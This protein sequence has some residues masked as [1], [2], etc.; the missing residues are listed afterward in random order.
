MD[1]FEECGTDAYI[2][3]DVK[4]R[5]RLQILYFYTVITHNKK[6]SPLH[7]IDKQYE[8]YFYTKVKIFDLKF[9]QY[10]VQKPHESEKPVCAKDENVDLQLGLDAPD[11]VY[12]SFFLPFFSFSYFGA[13]LSRNQ[14]YPSSYLCFYTS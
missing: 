8:A 14:T 7:V 2:F 6:Y 12:N 10:E 11:T 1:N 13:G 4:S 5:V 3:R 9:H